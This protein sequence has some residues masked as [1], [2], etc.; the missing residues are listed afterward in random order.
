MPHLIIGQPIMN[1]IY[2][3]NTLM[4]LSHCEHPFF[5]SYKGA[6]GIQQTF[7]LVLSRVRSGIIS[8]F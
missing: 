6:V 8:A 1:H 7:L 5:L 4:L 2:Y 3:V